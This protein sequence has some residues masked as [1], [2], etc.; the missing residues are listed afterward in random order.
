MDL[1]SKLKEVDQKYAAS[2]TPVYPNQTVSPVK[3][4][5]EE[6]S[7]VIKKTYS[8]NPAAYAPIDAEA[9]K[10]DAR[11]LNPGISGTEMA[12]GAIPV[13]MSML[14]GGN[15]AGAEVAAPYMTDLAKDDKKR[16]QNLEDKLIDMEL[17]RRAKKLEDES[18]S[19]GLGK[20]RFQP[21]SLVDEG[22][23]ET[24][25]A[26][27]DSFTG[28]YL[29]G[30]GQE[31]QGNFRKGFALNAEARDKKLLKEDVAQR[32]RIDYRPRTNPQTGELERINQNNQFEPVG[33]PQGDRLNVK[34]EAE[35]E[36]LVGTF[37]TTDIYKKNVQSL[38][39]AMNVD[40]L[41][42]A[43]NSGNATAANTAK[44][45]LARMAGEVGALS[46]T[47]VERSGGSQSLKE[48]AKRLANLERS[49]VPLTPMDINELKQIAKIYAN[50]AN[51]K[52]QE[53]IGNMETNY[54]KNFGGKPGAVETYMRSLYPTLPESLKN[55]F[56]MIL[57]KDGRQV[58]VKNEEEMKSANSKG[59][60]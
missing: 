2:R 9:I 32:G 52:L 47:D 30:A 11:T 28:K 20:K 40:S 23:G 37:K 53:A 36:K 6:D 43:A 4:V 22:N 56:P 25:V 39:Q 3:E 15:G 35:L 38:D 26:T 41:L 60:R 27:F 34:Q 54:V 58:T 51:R 5:T 44:I 49:R 59:W 24:I 46:D 13:A 57:Q 12:L 17:K 7:E 29:D 31:L 16:T 45:G 1:L 18:K 14:M 33:G 21:V 48:K 55:K 10:R 42:S 8:T 19:T 50:N